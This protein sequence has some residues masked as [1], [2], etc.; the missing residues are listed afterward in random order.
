MRGPSGDKLHTPTFHALLEATP[1]PAVNQTNPDQ[2]A[3]QLLNK[4]TKEAKI[5]PNREEAQWDPDQSRWTRIIESKDPKMIWR[6]IGWNGTLVKDA[7]NRPTDQEF[8]EHFEKLLNPSE[9]PQSPTPGNMLYIPIL[10]DH[11][12]PVEVEA[13]IQKGKNKAFLG[14]CTALFRSLPRQWLV[15]FTDLF[16]AVFSSASYPSQWSINRLVLLF[17]SGCHLDC[18]NYRGIAI[19]DSAAKIYDHL[20]LLLR[21]RL[22]QW[23]NIDAACT[24]RSAKRAKLH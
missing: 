14:V 6:A 1:V 4:T 18:G 17:K 22:S 13:A 2:S 9:R 15:F 21:K 24:G 3:R 23:S 8:R 7:T 5:R 10:D 12:T 11:F 16:N 20:Q 19:M